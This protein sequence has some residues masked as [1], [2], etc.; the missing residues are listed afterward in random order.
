MFRGS[1][2]MPKYADA[3]FNTLIDLKI[4]HPGLRCAYVTPSLD[5][6]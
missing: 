3:F 1:E 5:V 6:N 4:M 2:K